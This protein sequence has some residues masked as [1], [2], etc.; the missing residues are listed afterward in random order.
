MLANQVYSYERCRAEQHR[1]RIPH[2]SDQ[3]GRMSEKWNSVPLLAFGGGVGTIPR[4]RTK[5]NS[6]RLPEEKWNNALLF[7]F[8]RRPS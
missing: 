8:S 2:R 3:Q 6:V 5:W 4:A 7:L 1:R